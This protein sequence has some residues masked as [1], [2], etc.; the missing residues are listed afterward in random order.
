MTIVGVT[1]PV[2]DLKITLPT[3]RKDGSALAA[4]DIESLVILR[5]SVV[6]KTLPAPF[7]GTIYE[8]DASPVGES[9]AYSFYTVDT[10]G[11]RSEVSP[12]AIIT[13]SKEKPKAPPVAG[14]ISAVSHVPGEAVS[15]PTTV[16]P[17]PVALAPVPVNKTSGK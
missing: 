1:V 2:V 6:W 16:A 3:E 5:N 15:E 14:T 11:V 7:S 10:A 13:V 12:V 9:D 17:D 4:S 8:T